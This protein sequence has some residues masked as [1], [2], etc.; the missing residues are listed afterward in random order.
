MTSKFDYQPIP[1]HRTRQS[2]ES[3]EEVD[4]PLDE[5]SPHKTN[6]L[7]WIIHGVSV[8]A[9]VSL[10]LWIFF[11][12]PNGPGEA[13][14]CWE[15]YNYYCK[16]TPLRVR[17]PPPVNA[18]LDRKEFV[19]T[20]F[21]G[22]LW[23]ESPFKGPPSPAVEEAWHSVMKYGMISVTAQ[24]YERV[25]HS[26][27]T[28]VRF[29]D[30][31][32]GGYMATTIGTHHLHCLHY[33]WQDHHQAYFP[34]MARKAREVPEMY[35]RHFEHC[36]DYIRQSLMCNFDTGLITYNWVLQHQNPTPNS[37]AMHKCIDWD[38]VQG[39]LQAR[40]VEIPEGFAWKQPEGQESLPW[41]P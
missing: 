35:E 6:H 9:I 20:R 22:S 23:Y 27:R 36:V 11:S 2:S 14:R 16:F 37:N 8:V 17:E 26:T 25:Q 4:S 33:L 28:A 19:T 7:H 39:W 21:N 10:L 38:A 40:A 15:K 30:E 29:P 1:V 5:S 34:D 3:G 13:A 12:R 31:A 32:G 41:N 18:A 24:D